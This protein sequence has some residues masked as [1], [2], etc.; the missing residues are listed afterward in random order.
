MKTKSSIRRT[1]LSTAAVLFIVLLSA[2]QSMAAGT[3][4]LAQTAGDFGIIDQG[5]ADT[6]VSAADA[7]SKAQEEITPSQEYYIGRAV[8]ANILTNYT[9]YKGAP[10]LT[11]YLNKI[12]NAIVINSPKPE[13]YAGYHVA[14]LDSPEINAFSTSG[15]HIFVT[16]GLIGVATSEDTLAAVLAHEVAHVQL[17]H[18]IK[19]IK[20]S[21]FANAVVETANAASTAAT[22]TQ[23]KEL[24]ETFG[25]S[26]D[27][28]VNA[29]NNGYS[30]TQ[31]YDADTLA[32]SL[33]ASAGY[34]PAS[35]VTMLT[36]LREK[37]GNQTG[38]GFGKTHPSPERRIASVNKTLPSYKVEDTKSFRTARYKAAL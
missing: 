30:Q 34:D 24:T 11:A 4:V 16:R 19:S 28:A 8:G 7:W 27:E 5:T 1:V 20:S 3:G 14:I 23:L 37:Q 10:A 22:G 18:S 9:I 29:L 38:S 35:L 12:C 36:S 21:R 31:E 15:G 25:V 13:L 6:I 32:L 2:C 26:V 17:Q 33:M